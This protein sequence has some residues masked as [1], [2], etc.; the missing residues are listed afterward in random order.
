MTHNLDSDWHASKATSSL[1]QEIGPV[2]I[3]F[4]LE[5]LLVFMDSGHSYDAASVV[6]N[7]QEEVIV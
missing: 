7:V 5:S 3:L 4:I 1:S 2:V 6:K